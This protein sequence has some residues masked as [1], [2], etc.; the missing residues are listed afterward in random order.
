[1]ASRTKAVKI[2]WHIGR[3]GLAALFLFAGGMKL[4]NLYL[5]AADIERYRIV[6]AGGSL[7]IVFVLPWL[8]ITVAVCLFLQAWTRGAMMLTIGMFGMFVVA[9]ASAKIRGL[10][11]TC[12]CFGAGDSASLNIALVRS[13][14]FLIASV[15]LARLNGQRLADARHQR[16]VEFPAGPPPESLPP[17]ARD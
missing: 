15:I 8:E 14:V 13:S 2:C 1:M 16:T 4:R 10:D 11:I 12:G 3:I 6:G 9:M 17:Q 5:F 7:L